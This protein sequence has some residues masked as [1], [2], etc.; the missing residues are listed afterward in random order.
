[1]YRLYFCCSSEIGLSCQSSLRFFM[2]CVKIAEHGNTE[3]LLIFMFLNFSSQKAVFQILYNKVVVLV[4]VVAALIVGIRTTEVPYI[5]SCFTIYKNVSL[6]T[7]C[8]CILT[9]PWVNWVHILHMP[10]C[11][12]VQRLS[13]RQI[14]ILKEKQ[15]SCVS[16]AC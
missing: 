14:V 5:L 12:V 16:T 15:C 2:F 7:A 9:L 8:L 4:L 10:D 1:M 3:L 6:K 13:Q 11:S